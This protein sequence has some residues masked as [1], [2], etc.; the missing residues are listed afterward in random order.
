MVRAGVAFSVVSRYDPSFEYL[1]GGVV[2]HTIVACKNEFDRG[3][4]LGSEWEESDKAV[5]CMRQQEHVSHLGQHDWT[6]DLLQCG[7]CLLKVW[8]EFFA[9]F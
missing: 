6:R 1:E 2:C 8:S 5:Q 7:S 9:E 4:N 3:V